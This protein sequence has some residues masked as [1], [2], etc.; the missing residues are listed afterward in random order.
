L[1]SRNHRFAALFGENQA[2]VSHDPANQKP[3]VSLHKARQCPARPPTNRKTHQIVLIKHPNKMV[4]VRPLQLPFVIAAHRLKTKAS[5][6]GIRKSPRM[7]QRHGREMAKFELSRLC[8]HFQSRIESA[9]SLFEKPPGGAPGQL[10][11][12]TKSHYRKPSYRT[13]SRL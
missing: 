4:F 11:Y 9:Q 2:R 1:Q 7:H 13:L 3:F 8:E 10:A 5:Q 12:K 6:G